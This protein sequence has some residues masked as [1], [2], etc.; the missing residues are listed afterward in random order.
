M[1]KIKNKD[2]KLR[3]YSF[4]AMIIIGLLISSG[5]SQIAYGQEET[6]F[7][8][9]ETDEV[10][11]EET[12]PTP[13]PTQN[14]D[15]DTEDEIITPKSYGPFSRF[16]D[17]VNLFFTYN[18]E[19][20]AVK[21]L[22]IADK[23][24]SHILYDLENKGSD[25]EYSEEYER[26]MKTV[27][28]ALEKIE[29]NGKV[30]NSKAALSNLSK[31]EE[32]IENHYQKVVM[33]KE[34]ILERQREKMTEEQIEH[35]ESVFSNITQRFQ[36]MEDQFVQ[37]RERALLKYKAMSGKN[38]S[39]ID[40]ELEE[41]D[42]ETGLS[43]RRKSMAKWQ[44]GLAQNSL[45]LSKQRFENFL[46]SINETEYNESIAEI[47]SQLEEAEELLASSLASLEE[48][49]Y[50]TITELTQ[51][52]KE[53]GDELNK[54]IL[55][56]R[57]SQ[58]NINELLQSTKDDIASKKTEH[59]QKILDKVP[60]EAKQGIMNAMENAN[61]F[62]E[63]FAQGDDNSKINGTAQ[64]N[65]NKNENN[66]NG[67]LESDETDDLEDEEEQ[68]DQEEDEEELDEE[69]EEED[70]DDTDEEGEIDEEIGNEED[71]G[72]EEE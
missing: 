48:N 70:E 64:R 34:R 26:A 71:E 50:E 59:L 11:D 4:L 5:V 38:D 57:S 40:E 29:T 31:I 65:R 36:N 39:E 51:E 8:N 62:R 43:E 33:V 55:S 54:I 28:K 66:T 23:K 19:K 12:N 63:R 56:L 72:N 35:L 60:E 13:T 37:K 61:R 42:D 21:A 46:S 22:E 32:R 3:L 27:E 7:E 52:I 58:E 47:R 2:S 24:L 49:D 41:I 44:L 17:N 10:D 68:E 67:S 20:K 1:K 14:S 15:N 69:D 9:N 53:L 30:E 25:E 16:F 18:Q 45:K 6:E